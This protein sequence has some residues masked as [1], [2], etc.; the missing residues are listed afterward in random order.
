MSKWTDIREIRDAWLTTADARD[1]LPWA[2]RADTLAR[3]C[4]EG[5]RWGNVAPDA[6]HLPDAEPPSETTCCI[7]YEDFVDPIPAAGVVTPTAMGLF[8]CNH[9]PMCRT[10]DISVQGM[11]NSRCPLCRQPRAVR[12]A[13]RA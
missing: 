12:L 7:C 1:D 4:S 2:D 9:A 13:P 6:A 10:C 8:A 3:M 11:P 5:R